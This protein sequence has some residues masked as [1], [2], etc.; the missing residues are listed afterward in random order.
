MTWLYHTINYKLEFKNVFIMLM[1]S[2]WKGISIFTTICPL[3]QEQ[4]HHKLINFFL[5]LNYIN[6][7][8]SFWWTTWNI[9]YLHTNSFKPTFLSNNDHLW[10]STSSM[11]YFHPIAIQL[12]I[13]TPYVNYLSITWSLH[14][15]TCQFGPQWQP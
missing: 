2:I 11:R 1:I 14:V 4:H 3:D 15:T 5:T 6:I 8:T 10:Y 7:I 12:P 13:L 9:H